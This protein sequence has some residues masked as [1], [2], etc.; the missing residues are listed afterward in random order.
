[1]QVAAERYPDVAGQSNNPAMGDRRSNVDT[2]TGIPFPTFIEAAS[3]GRLLFISPH[4]DDAAFACGRL[5]ASVSDAIVATLSVGAPA[6]CSA[7]IE[8]DRAAGDDVVA[9]LQ[10]ED[11]QVLSQLGAWPLW[12][13]VQDRSVDEVVEHLLRLLVQCEPD[14]TFFPLGLSHADHQLTRQ[15]ASILVHASSGCRW[16]A[17]E[18]ALYR[19]LP[20]QR[21]EAIAE[22]GRAG[23]ALSPARFVEAPDAISRKERAIA[24]Y[25]SQRRALATPDRPGIA[26]LLADE[27]YWLVRPAKGAGRGTG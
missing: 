18:D 3:M 21:E 9:R 11:R 7:L 14:A 25:I 20:A 6:P 17:Y 26:D 13:E 1:M 19:R 4:L 24:C 22:L 15:A 10:E 16:F 8:S 27:A 12:L 2:D 5:V 23:L